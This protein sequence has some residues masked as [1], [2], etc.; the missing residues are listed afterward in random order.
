MVYDIQD[1]VTL[2]KT[3]RI[4]C[5]KRGYHVYDGQQEYWLHKCVDCDYLDYQGEPLDRQRPYSEAE[6]GS[7]KKIARLIFIAK[8]AFRILKTSY[9]ISIFYIGYRVIMLFT[10]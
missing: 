5:L 7:I 10:K 9:W 8:M 4:T 3:G 1:A 6:K 2:L